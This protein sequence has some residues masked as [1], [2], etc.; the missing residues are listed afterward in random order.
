MI[1]V[2]NV[3]GALKRRVLAGL[4]CV[5]LAVLSTARGADDPAELDAAWT[6]AAPGP[7]EWTAAVGDGDSAS[8]LVATTGGELHLLDARRGTARWREPVR[9]APGAR[10]AGVVPSGPRQNANDGAPTGDVCVFDR[11]AVYA[12]ALDRDDGLRWRQGRP[13]ASGESYPDDPEH[14]G[15][16]LG[17]H[18][19]DKGVLAV[20]RV[21]S[22]TRLLL[23]AADD[24]R[25]LWDV[26]TAP[27]TEPRL[28]VA[29]KRAAVL[30]PQGRDSWLLVTTLGRERPQPHVRRLPRWPAWSAAL[31]RGIVTVFEAEA[32]FWPWAA[33]PQAVRLD[34]AARAGR[35]ALWHR[36]MLPADVASRPASRPAAESRPPVGEAD[37]LIVGLED[38]LVAYDLATGGVVWR[39]VRGGEDGPL[40][41]IDVL[42]ASVVAARGGAVVAYCA[43]TGEV[44]GR[45]ALEGAVARGATVRDGV[46]HVVWVRSGRAYFSAT[47]MVCREDRPSESAPEALGNAWE[48]RGA[49]EPR[50]VRWVSGG[51]VLE[52][53]DGL[54]AYVMPRR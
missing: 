13:P 29:G 51:V 33:P 21:G 38:A 45:A 37:L 12:L 15:G 3:G 50:D 8:I 39:Q 52:T 7:I 10:P 16:W 23:L 43:A 18:A 47:P 9:A 17:A 2:A 26:P 22:D 35:V 28:H 34:G 48:L 46:L 30:W 5:L 44:V 20:R 49:T 53:R 32:T 11:H 42:G 6:W 40:E 31:E 19:T 41:R 54:R 4:G 1:A 25:P 27:V 14:L 24:G 36:A